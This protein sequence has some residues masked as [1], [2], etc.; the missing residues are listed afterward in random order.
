MILGRIATYFLRLIF[1]ANVGFASQTRRSVSPWLSFSVCALIV[2]PSD[3]QQWSLLGLN[4]WP[5]EKTVERPSVDGF[6]L[7]GNS[8]SRVLNFFPTP[9]QEEC[10]SQDKRRRGICMNTYECRIQRGKSYGRCALGF[11]VCCI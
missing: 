5:S 7:P 3:T 11:G 8:I 4:L 1:F 6:D 10:L 2:L 9:V